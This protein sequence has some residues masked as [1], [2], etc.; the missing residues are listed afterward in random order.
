MRS[1]FCCTSARVSGSRVRT[2]ASSTTASGITFDLV[3]PCDAA[4]GDHRRVVGVDL[5][6]HDALEREHDARGERHRI[7]RRVRIGAV[8]AAAA[9][10]EAEAVDVGG[11][12]ARAHARLA[13]SAMVGWSCSAKA[14]SMPPATVEHAG[15][16][17]LEGPRRPSPRPAGRSRRRCPAA[18]RAPR[19]ARAARRGSTLMWMSCPQACIT[20]TSRPPPA[21]RGTS[22][23]RARPPAR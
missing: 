11:G 21:C 13:R 17:H 18:G 12:R 20:P 22:R 8:A 14:R 15:L 6:R 2:V 5:A 10:R 4:D 1:I 19:P 16:D 7:D 23:R 3:P 9:H